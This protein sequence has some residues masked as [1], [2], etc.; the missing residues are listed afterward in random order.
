MTEW[1]GQSKGTLLGYKIFIFILKHIHLRV[2]YFIV[3]FVALYY[4]FFTRKKDIRYFYRQILSYTVLKSEVSIFGNY[5]AF[6]KILLDKFTILSGFNNTFT[7]HHDGEE[8]LYEMANAGKGGI[9]LG[10]HAGNWEIAGHLLSR[11]NRPVY[12]VIYDGERSNLKELIEETTGTKS[13][14]VIPVKDNDMQ[15]IYEIRNV[16]SEGNIVAMHGDRFRNGSKTY[17]C[18]FFERKAKFP[19][20]PYYLASQFDVPFCFVH[21]MKE[22]N[23]HYHFYS[24]PLMRI[25]FKDPK[26]KIEDIKSKTE[27]YATELEKMI[28]KYPLQWFNYYNFWTT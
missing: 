8:Y 26:S 28:R 16:L 7:Y 6:G 13:F 21:T 25:K 10:A 15:H 20:G 17:P 24:T 5:F 12:V 4:Y 1:D 2:A 22:T 9:I 3:W 23:T 19:L 18:N 14:H 27:L 11:L